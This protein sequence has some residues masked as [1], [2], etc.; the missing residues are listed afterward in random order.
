M[1]KPLEQNM[2]DDAMRAATGRDHAEWHALLDGAGAKGWSH[3]ETARWLTEEQGVAAWWAQG[4]TIGYEQARKG[5]IPGQRADGTFSTQKAKT[6]PGQRLDALAAVGAALTA[7]YGEPSGQNL[8]AALPIMRWRLADG[9]RLSASAGPENASGT[10]I[11]IAQEKL[12]DQATAE[13]AKAA[14]SELLEEIAR[15]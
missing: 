8:A 15:R 13:A 7:R 12:P 2:G 5:R 1:A 4:V 6:I 10:P 14:F 3:A 11:T 9:T